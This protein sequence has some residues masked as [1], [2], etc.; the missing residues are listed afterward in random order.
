MEDKGYLS[1]FVCIGP[2]WHQL[3]DAD[4][5]IVFLFLEQEGHLSHGKFYGLLFGKKE[6]LRETFLNLLFF[7][8]LQLKIINMAK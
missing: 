7:K 4:G 2:F 5:K 3:P 1:K 8:C 6:K